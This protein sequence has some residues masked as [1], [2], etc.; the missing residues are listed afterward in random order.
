MLM[1]RAPSSQGSLAFLRH[2]A[3]RILFLRG[4]K[5]KFAVAGLLLVLLVSASLAYRFFCLE[6]DFYAPTRIF[7]RHPYANYNHHHHQHR[8]QQHHQHHQHHNNDDEDDDDNGDGRH[9]DVGGWWAEFFG[10]LES[11]RVTAGPVRVGEPGPSINW[12]PGINA[13]RPDLIELSEDDVARFRAS[14][15]GFVDQLAEFA[16]HLPYE[17]DTTGIVTTTG[18]ATFGQAVSLVLMARRAGS[19]LPIQ[20]FLDSSSPWVDRLC[21][22][23]MPRFDARCVSLEDTWGGVR[24]PVPELVRFQWKVVSIVGSSFQNVLFLDADCLPVRSPDAIFDRRSEPFASAGLVT[25]PDFW[26]TNT[27][28]LFYRIAGDLDVP[29]VTARTS[30]ESGMM[31]YDKARHADT[32]LLAAYYNYNGPDHYYPIFSQRG[33]GE[34]D[35][36]SFLQAALVL[37]ALRKKGAYRPPTAWMRPGVGVRKGYYDVKEL[38]FVHGR[39]AKQAWRGMFMMQQDPMADYRAFTAVL[40]GEEEEEAR[41]RKNGTATGTD[42]R[43]QEL[44]PDSGT[45]TGSGSAVMTVIRE[46]KVEGKKKKKEKKKKNGEEEEEEELDEDAFLTDTTALDRFGDL[47]PALE[48]QK[49]KGG[50]GSERRRREHVMFFHHNGVNPDFTRVLDPESGLVETDEEGRYVRL[51]GDPGWI[52]DCLGRDAE[53]LLWEDT[54]AVYCQP[55][56]VA[57]FER[58]RRVCAHMRDIHQQLYV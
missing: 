22:E 38:P 30:P 50:G 28:P 58:L 17:A 2:L 55:G 18:V 26:V 14:H 40:E 29:P 32:L 13:T 42:G 54:M 11:T 4:S 15:A 6:D 21:A 27:S 9:D 10:R 48:R 46:K 20:I 41:R 53:K 43:Q 1:M 37:Q 25:W 24:G 51:W 23:T 7:G 34:G 39:S 19:R 52:A 12:A 47:T 56:L 3:L 44:S 45:G 5:A 31:A 16:S 8:H 33:A 49:E 36:E 35:R 57:R